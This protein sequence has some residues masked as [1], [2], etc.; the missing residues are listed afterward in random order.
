MNLTT[1]KGSVLDVATKNGKSIAETFLN[2]DVV[3]IIDT[4]GSMGTH[5][6]DHSDSR[7]ERACAELETLQN[8]IPGRVAV[9]AFSDMV[10]FCP[11]G[12]PIYFGL[13]TDMAKALLYAKIA[14]VPG[15]RFILISDGQ[16]YDEQETLSAA[17][18]YKNKID[19]IF[20]G[21]EK[22]PEGMEFLKRLSAKTGGTF[23]PTYEAKELQSSIEQLLLAG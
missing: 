14:D 21:S 12:K 5:D 3:T 20:I 18:Q 2:C 7:Y 1:Y 11:N 15:V 8:N 6:D 23:V 19:T 9:I 13:G 17:A 4:S 22:H 10:M 16:P